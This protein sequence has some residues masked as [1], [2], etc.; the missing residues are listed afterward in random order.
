MDE[1]LIQQLAGLQ[2]H[3]YEWGKKEISKVI[4]CMIPFM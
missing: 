1:L 2:G 3:L 4:Y